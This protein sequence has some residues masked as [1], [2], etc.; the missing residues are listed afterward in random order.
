MVRWSLFRGIR[1]PVGASTG[2]SSKF[3]NPKFLTKNKFEE[4]NV[5]CTAS[6]RVFEEDVEQ[7]GR[8]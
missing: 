8:K 5:L 6:K 7:G 4:R 3:A 1:E 2:L